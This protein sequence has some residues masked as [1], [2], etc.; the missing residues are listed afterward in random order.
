[1]HQ[2]TGLARPSTLGVGHIFDLRTMEVDA[3]RSFPSPNC[4]V[5]GGMQPSSG[6]GLQGR[7]RAERAAGARARR[8]P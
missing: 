2:L 8:A 3:S 5:C 7:R 1:M 4:P 6:K